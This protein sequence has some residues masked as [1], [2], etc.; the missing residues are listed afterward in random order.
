MKQLLGTGILLLMV[1]SRGGSLF[2]ICGSSPYLLSLTDTIV[3][4]SPDWGD[5][6]ANLGILSLD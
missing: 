6:G 4:L 2:V 5:M 3:A 1:K